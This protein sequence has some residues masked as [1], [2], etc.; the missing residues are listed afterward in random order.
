MLEKRS[1]LI[2]GRSVVERDVKQAELREMIGVLI[3]RQPSEGSIEIAEIGFSF[4]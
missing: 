3:S 2:S 1:C 4:R